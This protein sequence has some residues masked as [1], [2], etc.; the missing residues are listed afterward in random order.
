MKSVGT[1]AG[2]SSLRG[3]LT[4][5]GGMMVVSR[6][7]GGGS[8]GPGGQPHRTTHQGVGVVAFQVI[9]INIIFALL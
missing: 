9:V 4:F 3:L 1:L 5:L 8:G 2:S 6:V 7:W